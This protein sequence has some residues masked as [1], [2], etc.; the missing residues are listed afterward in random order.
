M[1]IEHGF[2]RRD[3]L[4]ATAVMAA[5]GM[6][7]S[8]VG[9][10]P[11]SAGRMPEAMNRLPGYQPCVASCWVPGAGH[12][13]YYHL[14]KKT[15]EAATDFSWLRPGDR[16]LV[17]L[18]LNSG[19]PF[20]ATS[21]PWSLYCV[22]KLLYEKGAG[23]V[24]AGDQ[25]GVESVHWTAAAKRGSS[26][27]CCRSAGLLRV[28]DETGARPVFFEEA[29]YDA[30]RETRSEG[31]SHWDRPLYVSNILDQVDHLVYLPRVGSHIMGDITSGMK[32]GVGFLREDSRLL[33]HQG[34][35]AFYAMYEE[36][37]QVPEIRSRLRLLISS[38]R[39]VLANFGP[40][41]GHVVA[42][43]QGLVF[44]STDI[45]AHEVFASAWLKWNR[46][47]SIPFYS[48]ATSGTLT[49]FRSLINKGFVR[50]IWKDDYWLNAT[51]SLPFY[52]AGNIYSHPAVQNALKRNG[53]L[54]EDIHWEDINPEEADAVASAFIRGC[55]LTG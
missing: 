14:F 42:P 43:G 39:R 30:Y 3:F 35:S 34:G 22:V 41:N 23:Q 20:P 5:A 9:L 21:D 8:C 40:D 53:G 6:M 16:V 19:K 52:Q 11:R 4:K 55:L 45:L 49:R 7:P 31:S 44:A 15:A 47:E 33:F 28:I 12:P 50:W 18:A 32:L 26:R 54:P 51:P 13:D 17:K 48:D 27:E 46:R 29:G 24:L 25:S 10:N 38:G 36:V 37:N 2:S 1:T